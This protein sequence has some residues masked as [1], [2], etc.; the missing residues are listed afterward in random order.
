MRVVITLKETPEGYVELLM[1]SEGMGTATRKEACYAVN[2]KDLL[3]IEMPK[4][5][6]ALGGQGVISQVGK[7]SNQ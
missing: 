4:L 6:R 2:I 7:A 3:K 1:D 5:C